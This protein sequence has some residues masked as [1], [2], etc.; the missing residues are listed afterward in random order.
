MPEPEDIIKREEKPVEAS[1]SVETPQ[2]VGDEP[3]L[4]VGWGT[5][6]SPTEK[7]YGAFYFEQMSDDEAG[8]R[9]LN[10]ALFDTD[11]K[12]QNF[13]MQDKPLLFQQTFERVTSISGE[14]TQ[15]D[16]K[17]A[18]ESV[19]KF[20]REP[21]KK[22]E[23]WQSVENFDNDS[24]QEWFYRLISSII[25]KGKLNYSVK[26]QL[27]TQKALSRS[28]KGAL[29]EKHRR[30]A[31]EDEDE[32]ED[33][34]KSEHLLSVLTIPFKGAPPESLQSEDEIY[35]RAL[36]AISSE[37]PEELQ[38]EKY[39]F[40]S[41]PLEATVL[42]VGVA[43]KLPPTYEGNPDDYYEVKASFWDGEIGS[44]YIFKDERVKMVNMPEEDDESSFDLTLIPYFIGIGI[45][46]IS[47][48][49]AAYMIFG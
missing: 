24:A 4:L 43:D 41:K 27:I 23:L 7:L 8:F 42:G 19:K 16:H 17:Q 39:D 11:E 46:L 1:V 20:L 13:D 49:V 12:L 26:I 31:G 15:A 48:A 38:S 29:A 30:S 44:G 2:L 25:P 28:M 40:A 5:F 9:T 37:L 36:G 3:P 18:R 10:L 33:E 6:S 45:I 35:V 21:E 14:V 22:S 47:L 32:E 34:L